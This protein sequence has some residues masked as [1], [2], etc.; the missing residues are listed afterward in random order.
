MRVQHILMRHSGVSDAFDDVIAH[1]LKEMDIE[2]H[3]PGLNY[4]GS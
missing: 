2:F 4:H 1:I 3:G